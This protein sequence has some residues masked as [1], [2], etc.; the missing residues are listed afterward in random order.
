M[1]KEIA[2]IHCNDLDQFWATISPIGELFDN[3][4]AKFIYRGQRNHKWKL[5]PK[6]CREDDFLKKHKTGMAAVFKDHPGQCF[7]EWTFLKGFID[8]CD[9]MGLAMPNDSMEFR[10]YFSQNKITNT[11]GIKTNTWPPERVVPLMALAQHHGIATRLLDFTGNPYIAAYFAASSAV[12]EKCKQKDKLSVYALN[13]NKIGSYSGIKHV[14]V[15]GST[16]SNLSAQNGSFIL[17][18]NHGYRGDLFEPNVSIE[19]KIQFDTSIL[20]HVTLPTSLAGE[21]LLRCHKFGI[22]AAS[23]FPGY[24]GAAKAVLESSLAFNYQSHKS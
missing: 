21:L 13:I 9:S 23:V 24:D 3:P 1:K 19:S 15:P 16:S 4:G 20:K 2:T 18:E 5:I 22:S 8:Y 6:V 12:A 14:A 11:F 17:V 7:F 10:D